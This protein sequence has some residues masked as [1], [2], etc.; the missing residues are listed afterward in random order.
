MNTYYE[1]KNLIETLEDD[2][3]KVYT[4]NN[5]AAAVRV[6]KN[7]QGIKDVAQKLRIEINETRKQWD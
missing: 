3:T 6:R 2:V 5:K 7:L 4:K 1:L